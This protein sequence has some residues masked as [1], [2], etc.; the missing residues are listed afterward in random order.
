VAAYQINPSITNE[1]SNQEILKTIIATTKLPFTKRG[2][3]TAVNSKLKLQQTAVGPC[4]S[5]SHEVKN[6]GTVHTG[7]RRG[8]LVTAKKPTASS[9]QERREERFKDD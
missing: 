4:L 6:S 2:K 3:N 8:N 5:T 1:L 7:H 9:S